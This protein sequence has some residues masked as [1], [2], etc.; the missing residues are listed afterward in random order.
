MYYDLA[1]A[2]SARGSDARVR[3]HARRSLLPPSA[4]RS[5][6]EHH[7]LLGYKKRDKNFYE[8]N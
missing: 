3:A 4:K 7:C 5:S 2:L 8:N 6:V 1:L